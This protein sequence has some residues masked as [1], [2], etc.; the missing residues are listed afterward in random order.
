MVMQ[1]VSTYLM[2]VSD[3]TRKPPQVAAANAD[4]V[5]AM[6]TLMIGKYGTGCNLRASALSFFD[7]TRNDNSHCATR[8]AAN[9]ATTPTPAPTPTHR[10]DAN[11]E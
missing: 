9:G 10:D 8:T 1:H 3:S 11:M 4:N 5:A 2:R 7:S 6:G